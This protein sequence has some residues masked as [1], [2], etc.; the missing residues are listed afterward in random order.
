MHQG[1]TFRLFQQLRAQSESTFNAL[2]IIKSESYG[3]VNMVNNQNKWDTTKSVR[4]YDCQRGERYNPG[5]GHLE[6]EPGMKALTL[7]VNKN[8][9]YGRAGGTGESVRCTWK[10]SLQYPSPSSQMV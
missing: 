10:A 4:L 7:D 2:M 1:M 9:K 5:H 8:L 6:L 3:T